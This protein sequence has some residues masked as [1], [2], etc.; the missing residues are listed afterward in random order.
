MHCTI[1]TSVACP[2]LPSF[3]TLPHKWHNFE[4]IV[5]E[6]KMCVLIF[7][8]TLSK[9]FL[10]LRRIQQD[11]IVKVHRLHVKYSIFLSDFNETEIFWTDCQNIHKTQI[12]SKPF[13]W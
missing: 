13:R 9:P 12:P 6:H 3:S 7:S 5:I 8:P 11:I 2:A 1:L 4:K 10:G